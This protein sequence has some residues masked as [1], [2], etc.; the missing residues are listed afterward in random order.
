MARKRRGSGEGTIVQ[1]PDGRWMAQATVGRD[2]ETGK[3]KRMTLY[4]RTRMEVKEKLT[5][6]LAELDSGVFV[7]PTT[8]TVGDW[9]D[10]WFKKYV[11]DNVSPCTRDS[12]E[13]M[14]RR[15]IKPGLGSIQLR[16]LQP[17]HLQGFINERLQ[18]GRVDGRGGL[19][20]KSVRNMHT[21]I[22]G[23]L[24]QA[25]REQLIPRNP[26]EAVKLPKRKRREIRPLT[27]SEIQ[28]LLKTVRNHRLYAAFVL[29]IGSGLRRGEILALRWSDVDLERGLVR[30]TRSLERVYAQDSADRRTALV[31][32]EPKTE[33][34][35]RT[36]PIPKAAIEALRHHRR[37]QLEE[38]ILLGGA[39][40]DQ[41]LVF[42]AENGNPLDPTN[43]GHRFESVLAK[44]GLPHVSFHAL[45]H[46]YATQ[47]LEA[48]EHPKVVQ[49]L[50]G[51][52]NITTTLDTYSHVIMGLKERAARRLDSILAVDA[53]TQMSS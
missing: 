32:Q 45:R 5:R 21:I 41:N 47:L 46:T 19:S 24:K 26:A 6:V 25:V 14:I 49:E 3:I 16:R 52:T 29:A 27:T 34:S 31:F 50:L 11:R 48:G 39:Y 23:A 10:L 51:H 40:D 4:G 2:P 35:K 7:E 18:N 37:R 33:K 12:Y 53:P 44:A 1:R 38:R 42:A 13:T 20:P 22:Y 9:F 30:V 43:F 8:T 28:H 36:L 15:H 17:S